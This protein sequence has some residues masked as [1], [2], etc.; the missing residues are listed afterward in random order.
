MKLPIRKHLP[1]AAGLLILSAI[2]AYQQYQLSTLSRTVNGA[3][4]KVSI[5]A[6]QNR[7]SAIDDRLDTVSGKPLVTMEDFRV[8]QQA[9]S[10][11][12]D[13]VQT[14]AKQ[15]H[16]AA[17]EVTRS[18]ATAGDL[19]VLKADL[20]SLNGKLQKMS[21]PQVQATAPA[22][23]T[24]SKPKPKP[25]PVKAPPIPQDPPPFQMVGLEYRGGERFLSVAPTGSTRLSQ[26][27]LI[28]PGEV[29]SGSNW[30]LRAVDERTATF[31]AGGTTRT[32]SIQP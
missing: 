32:L 4:E 23:K 2:I 20:E 22:P 11:R 10:S 28:R 30:R 19:L 18:S 17:A 7:V 26:I 12:I 31:D 15:A 6:L 27:Y 8:S 21:K 9:L 1:I 16:E 25:A 13:A 29:V 24:S 3:A 5:D 14:T